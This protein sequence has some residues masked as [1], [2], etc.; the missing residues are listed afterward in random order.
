MDDGG[1]MDG[2]SVD[3]YLRDT[4]GNLV[5]S[6]ANLHMPVPS[7]CSLKDCS[8]DVKTFL[9]SSPLFRSLYLN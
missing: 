6:F 7:R 1:S 9:C 4:R 2:Q 3:Q 5:V 8:F